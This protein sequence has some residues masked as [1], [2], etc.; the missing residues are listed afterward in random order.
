ERA[1]P[2]PRRTRPPPPPSSRASLAPARPGAARRPPG[3]AASAR[4]ACALPP[5]RARSRETVRAP[6]IGP[7]S[8]HRRH[9]HRI[10]RDACDR[11]NEGTA[12]GV[13]DVERS[14][15]ARRDEQGLVLLRRLDRHARVLERD[16]ADE[17]LRLW[18]DH[19][20]FGAAVL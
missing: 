1:V 11:A 20:G 6:I 3:S 4:P 10:V 16:A 12:C 2:A 13:I 19:P 15:G 8:A 7:T 5:P 17:R 9:R 18:I 14:I